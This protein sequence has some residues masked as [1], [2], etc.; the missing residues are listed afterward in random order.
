MLWRRAGERMAHRDPQVRLG[1]E[2]SAAAK[3]D[4]VARGAVTDGL[5]MA[6][7]WPD[8]GDSSMC[9]EMSH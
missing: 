2:D 3:L 7:R 1:K 5:E 9:A 6:L 4:F 8:D